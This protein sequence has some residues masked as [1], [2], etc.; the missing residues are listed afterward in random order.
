MNNTIYF[1]S[2]KVRQSNDKSFFP[3]LVEIIVKAR[4]G[5]TNID[6]QYNSLGV[7]H[8]VIDPKRASISNSTTNQHNMVTAIVQRS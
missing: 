7:V 2:E 3:E 4:G 5:W 6:T 1:D 8:L